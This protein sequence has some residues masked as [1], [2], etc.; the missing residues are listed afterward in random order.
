M[1]AG[2]RSRVA[3]SRCHACELGVGLGVASR[4]I[5]GGLVEGQLA[6]A[7]WPRR[8]AG[9]SARASLVRVVRAAVP[10]SLGKTSANHCAPRRNPRLASHASSSASRRTSVAPG[11][12]ALTTPRAPR[13]LP[14]LT[15]TG[16]ALPLERLIDC[17]LHVPNMCSYIPERGLPMCAD[18]ADYVRAFTTHP[19]EHHAAASKIPTDHP[20]SMIDA[21]GQPDP[22]AGAP[23]RPARQRRP[24]A[25]ARAAR[26]AAPRNA[27]PTTPPVDERNAESVPPPP[28]EHAAKNAAEPP[29]NAE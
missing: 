19:P 11:R 5:G 25:A 1:R 4:L 26:A 13:R 17:P 24:H 28:R 23:N 21:R 18:N 3:L 12:R 15:P 2:A 20:Q 8:G 27:D 14:K 16:C 22:C 10:W 29:A 6:L 9:N 7:R